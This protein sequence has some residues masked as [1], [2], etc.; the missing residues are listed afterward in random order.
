MNA[1]MKKIKA[2]FFDRDGT[3]IKDVNY[4]SDLDQKSFALFY[5][6]TAINYL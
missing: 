6:K 2:A 3:L 5:K 1:D 4:L